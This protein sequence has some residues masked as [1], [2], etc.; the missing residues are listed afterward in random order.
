MTKQARTSAYVEG[1]R[2]N[3]RRL[4][5]ASC[6]LQQAIR[7]LRA[8]WRATAVV[9]HINEWIAGGEMAG[10]QPTTRV[11]PGSKLRAVIGHGAKPPRIVVIFAMASRKSTWGVRTFTRKTSQPKQGCAQSA[12]DLTIQTSGEARAGGAWHAGAARCP[13]G[14]TTQQPW[15]F[16]GPPG[17][18]ASRIPRPA[19]RAPQPATRNRNPQ[20]ATGNPP[21]ATRTP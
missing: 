21:P 1:A 18:P 19:P 12:R 7:A 5:C 20:P 15:A 11:F 17:T 9:E 13:R 2:G 8:R 14:R 10:E 3:P 4:D 16:V 6:H